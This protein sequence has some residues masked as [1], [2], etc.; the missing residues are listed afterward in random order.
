MPTSF[1]AINE[2]TAGLERRKDNQG[3]SK[4]QL[5]VWASR[6]KMQK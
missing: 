1:F 5:L 4:D 3:E 6:I 2:S